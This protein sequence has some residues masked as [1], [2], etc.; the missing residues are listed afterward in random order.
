AWARPGRRARHNLNYWQ[1]GDYLGLG[2]G[3]HGKLSY[4]DRIERQVRYRHPRRYV[5]AALAGD[6][7]EETRRLTP[8]DLPFEFMLNALRLVDGVPAALFAER[9]GLSAAAISRP[10]ARALDRGLIDPDP[11]TIRPTALGLRFLNDL[12]AMFLPASGRPAP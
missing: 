3:A 10:M 6:A 1:F 8:T 5:E 2:A 4:H 9:T 11:A 7:I 12:Q